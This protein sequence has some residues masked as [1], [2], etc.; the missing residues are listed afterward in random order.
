VEAA[1]R[2]GQYVALDAADTLG[3]FMK[4]GSPD[5]RLFVDVV[6]GVLA[7]ARSRYAGLRALVA[8]LR[9]EGKPEAVLRL[10]QLWN[11]LSRIHHFSLVCAYPSAPFFASATEA[12]FGA[13]CDAHSG[14]LPAGHSI[15][16]TG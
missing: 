6:G 2:R 8:L 1:E 3:R 15:P 11:A 14:V 13:V 4:S 5:E 10:E 16:E 9:G 12:Q 7:R